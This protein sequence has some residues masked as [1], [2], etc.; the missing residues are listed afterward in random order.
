MSLHNRKRRRR[1]KNLNIKFI[2]LTA[3]PAHGE[4]IS[5]LKSMN[6]EALMKGEVF[7]DETTEELDIIENVDENNLNSANIALEVR[8][9]AD[10]LED[11]TI[12]AEDAIERLRETT[13]HVDNSISSGSDEADVLSLEQARNHFKL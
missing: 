9:I 7:E 8:S 6:A 3:H 1:L 11:G 10:A 4:P 13:E 2:A 5:V 12:K